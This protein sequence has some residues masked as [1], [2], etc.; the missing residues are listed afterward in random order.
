[1]RHGQLNEDLEMLNCDKSAPAWSF[2]LHCMSTEFCVIIKYERTDNEHSSLNHRWVQN[3]STAHN[4]PSMNVNNLASYGID[5][6]EIVRYACWWQGS[7]VQANELGIIN[8]VI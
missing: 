2:E 8:G 6:S 4:W 7:Q 3:T 5:S 1:M